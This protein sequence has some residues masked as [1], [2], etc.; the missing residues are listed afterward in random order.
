ML[1]ESA[2][3]ETIS[4]IGF[5]ILLVLGVKELFKFGNS[6]YEKDFYKNNSDL[7]DS[8]FEKLW[9]LCLSEGAEDKL[10]EESIRDKS[11]KVT[12][13]ELELDHYDFLNL[14]MKIDDAFD[15]DYGRKYW[16]VYEIPEDIDIDRI[17]LQYMTKKIV[18]L[19]N[20]KKN[21]KIYTE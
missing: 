6:L 11:K 21:N 9:E 14:S 13:K 16:S 12:I 5:F 20:K 17:S 18:K 7:Y 8:V 10:Y 4:R 15:I 2:I 19:I 3:I 1:V